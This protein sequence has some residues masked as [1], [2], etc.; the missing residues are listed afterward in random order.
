MNR[1]EQIV[2]TEEEFGDRL[3]KAVSEQLKLLA[4]ARYVCVVKE[5]EHGIVV[6]QFQYDRQ[7]FGEAYPYW[8]YPEEEE[9]VVYKGEEG[10]CGE[11]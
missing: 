5:E 2:F 7:E 3:W 8:L 9:M 10:Q 11:E 4:E 1:Y 6:I